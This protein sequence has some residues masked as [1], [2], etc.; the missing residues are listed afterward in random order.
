M[1]GNVKSRTIVYLICLDNGVLACNIKEEKY[2]LPF[3]V[4]D[5]LY[6]G[7]RDL[8]NEISEKTKLKINRGD[9]TFLRFFKER[10]DAFYSAVIDLNRKGNKGGAD[11]KGIN[12]LRAYAVSWDD[13]SQMAIDALKTN[14]NFRDA[15][16]FIDS[17]ETFIYY[18]LKTKEIISSV[19]NNVT[20]IW[21]FDRPDV[22]VET[23]NGITGVEFFKINASGR[24]DGGSIGA[25]GKKEMEKQIYSAEPGQVRTATKHFDNSLDNL[26]DDFIARYNHHLKISEYK[27]RLSSIFPGKDISIGFFIEDTTLLGTYYSTEKANMVILYIFNLQEFWDLFLT[28]KDLEFVIFQQSESNI[29]NM[30]F[31]TKDDYDNLRLNNQIFK[32][33]EVEALFYNDPNLI[34]TSIPI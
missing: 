10:G 9:L 1:N 33:D 16:T 8:K 31:I 3:I 7:I 30:V 13:G 12:F 4:F 17:D 2:I 26:W 15:F 21:Q 14:S 11:A 32:K 34:G 25:I 27:E 19:F 5:K 22:V 28:N 23:L 24:N 18:S 29:K 6:S 20:N